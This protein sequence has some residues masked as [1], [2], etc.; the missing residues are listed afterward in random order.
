MKGLKKVF[1]TAA[2]LMAAIVVAG[3]MK[4]S[5]A[6]YSINL[7]EEKE[8]SSNNYDENVIEFKAP[9]NGGFHIEV[10]LTDTINSKGESVNFGNVWLSATMVYNYK[11][12]WNS[13]SINRDKGW[14]SSPE[15]CL[16]AG[17]T[18]SLNVKGNFDNTTYKYKVKVVND[19]DK[20]YEKEDNGTAKKA[21]SIKVKKVYSGVI[22]DGDDVDWFVFKAKKAGKYK[23]SAV[24]TENHHGWTS[25]TGYKT[26][27]KKDGNYVGIYNERGWK[28]IKT[29]SLKKGQ[30]YYIKVAHGYNDN[31][32]YKLKVKKVS[33]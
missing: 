31:A 18:V 20:Y 30:K 22:N 2:A 10:V 7:N 4:V 32:T 15:Y 12:M 1:G 28:K 8:F 14:T 19:A 23:F 29:V 6:N 21:T 24:N 17:S 5:A 9:E 3:G 25:F 11:T 13:G 16:P 26:K 27:S 33:K